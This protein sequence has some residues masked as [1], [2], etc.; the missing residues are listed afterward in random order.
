M[1]RLA[2]LTR[3]AS[4]RW[5]S[6]GGLSQGERLWVRKIHFL[7]KPFDYCAGKRVRV[8]EAV[9]FPV[10]AEYGM[11]TA[12]EPQLDGWAVNVAVVDPDGT[13]SVAGTPVEST[14]LAAAGEN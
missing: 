3:R 10:D 12:T 13:H 8:V 4:A 11:G 7:C 6:R 9:T 1:H 14:I 5:L 2:T